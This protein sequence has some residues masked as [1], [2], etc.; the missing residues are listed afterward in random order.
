MGAPDEAFCEPQFAAAGQ[1]HRKSL[2]MGN[3]GF[4]K[5]FTDVLHI[6][7]LG[8]MQSLDKC[9]EVELGNGVLI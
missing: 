1:Q 6:R 4:Q 7:L 2:Q 9:I 3:T 8:I 5:S